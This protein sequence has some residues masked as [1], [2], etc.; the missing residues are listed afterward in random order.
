[1]KSENKERERER[2]RERLIRKRVGTGD[3][4]T[5]G[6]ENQDEGSK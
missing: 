4:L 6:T 5:L 1:M 2:E 3:R